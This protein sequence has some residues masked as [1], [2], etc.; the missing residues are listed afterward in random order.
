LAGIDFI[1]LTLLFEIGL[2]QTPTLV[3]YSVILTSLF[4]GLVLVV[5][6]IIFVLS[7]SYHVTRDLSTP[8]DLEDDEEREK[9]TAAVTADVKRSAMLT[10]KGVMLFFIGV[11]IYPIPLMIMFF[12]LGDVLGISAILVCCWV[13]AI[14][15]Y[16][17]RKQRDAWRR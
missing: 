9:R 14:F 11:A 4:S 6:S 1:I 16:V 15:F 12:L 8:F 5:S 7:V 10:Q 13:L 3:F 2:Q 17:G